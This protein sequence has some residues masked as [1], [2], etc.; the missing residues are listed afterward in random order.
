MVVFFSDRLLMATTFLVSFD[1]DFPHFSLQFVNCLHLGVDTFSC[2]ACLYIGLCAVARD[3][4]IPD[5]KVALYYSEY[6]YLGN[7]VCSLL[8]YSSNLGYQLADSVLTCLFH[9]PSS[10]S[11]CLGFE[12][13]TAVVMKSII[14]W[15]V[16]PCSL[17]RYNRRFGGTY[18]L[19]LQGPRKFQQEPASKQISNVGCISTDY[20]ASHSRR[21]YSSEVPVVIPEC[22]CFHCQYHTVYVYDETCL[23]AISR[24]TQ[25]RQ[26]YIG[27]HCTD[28]IIEISHC[29]C[30]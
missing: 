20:T 23:L 30:L 5:N 16:T 22:G 6:N 28:N 21:W 3:N 8:T 26:P 25:T 29:F 12:V 1:C 27:G 19:H 17:L 2:A 15:D 13:F 14:F 9:R 10:R 11:T 18:R 24:S 4:S 7:T